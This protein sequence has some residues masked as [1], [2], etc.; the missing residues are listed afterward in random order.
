M[1][2]VRGPGLPKVMGVVNVTPD[3]FSDR[4]LF[5]DPAQA[6]A[7]GRAL[8][9]D[10]ADLIDVGGE[11]TRPPGVGGPD[12]PGA[13]PVPAEEERRRVV[14][15]VERLASAGIAVSI[16]TAKAPVAEAALDAGA[17]MV[18]DVMALRGDPDLAGLCAERDCEVVL[19]H[20]RGTPRTMQL[21]PTY[22]DVVDDVKAFLV[23]RIEFATG[24]GIAE[25][26]IWVDPGIGFGK[27]VEHNLELLRR[28]G[29]LGELGRPICVGTSRKS[30]IGNIT[31]R[32]VDQRLGGTI[33]SC[34]LAYANGVEMLRVHDVREVREALAVAA[35]ILGIREW[36][37]PRQL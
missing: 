28:L 21:K 29:E 17:E 19:M 6:I 2:S 37:G 11:S 22:E 27:T 34:V 3:S 8:S 20:M 35:A 30:F 32:P 33:A 26:R 13:E 36:A 15:V 14:P 7:H 25:E 23:E 5:L 10:G 1:G 16:D 4:G 9:A 18:N 24:E 31:G 12:D